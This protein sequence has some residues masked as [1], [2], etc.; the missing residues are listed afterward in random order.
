LSRARHSSF[1]LSW[2]P[3]NVTPI[4]MMLKLVTVFLFI[5]LA[6]PAM[7]DG[8]LIPHEPFDP[9]KAQSLPVT[10]AIIE[11]PGLSH[12]FLVELADSEEERR[13]G[14]MHRAELPPDRGMLFRFPLRRP[15]NM[16]M[17]NTFVS[18]DMLFLNS[19]GE[20]IR[21]EED[22]V[23]HSEILIPSVRDARAVLELPAGTT[24]RLALKEG[25][26]VRHHIFGTL[27][28]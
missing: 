4:G 24:H 17:R 14:L 19:R 3:D 1:S 15:I 22:T 5:M 28:Q 23:P 25:N 21:I 18:L 7:A 12:K 9:A 2:L 6:V 26:Y 27:Q 20:I 11:G 13:I 16:W 10:P 8:Q